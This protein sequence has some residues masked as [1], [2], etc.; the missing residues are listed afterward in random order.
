MKKRFFLIS[1]LLLATERV[2]LAQFPSRDSLFTDRVVLMDEVIVSA[3]K[4]A[5]EKIVVAQQIESISA[6]QV[7]R[8]NPATTAEMLSNTGQVSVQ[9]SQQGGGSPVL[10]G[11]E[12]SRVLLM[13]DGVRLNNIIYRAGHLQNIITMDPSFLDRTEMLFGPSSTIY[14]SDALGGV[15]HLHTKKPQLS[16]VPGSMN[17]HGN[18]FLRYAS[19]SNEKTGHLDFNIGGSKFASFTSFSYSDFDDLRQGKNLNSTADSLWLRP[20]YAERIN[21]E[22]SLLKN[23]NIYKQVFSGYSQYD[24]LEKILFRQNDHVKHQ[25]NLQWSNSSDIPR[26]D[27]LTDPDG[28][29]LRY[30]EWYYGPQLRSL[31]AYDLNINSTNGFFNDYHAG[32]SYQHIE[33]SRHQ[34]RFGRSGLQS[35]TEKVDVIGFSADARKQT[36]RNDLRIGIDGQFNKLK[37]T[38]EERDIETNEISALDTRYPDGDNTINHF[39]LYASDTWRIDD[40]WILNAGMR[41]EYITLHSTFVSTEFFDFPFDAVDQNHF[42]LSGSLGIIWNGADQ[43]RISLLGSTGFRAPDVDDLAKVFESGPGMVIVPNPDLQPEKTY[44]ADLNVTK[45]FSDK[46]KVEAVGFYTLFRDAIVTDAF[47]FNGV[48]SIEYNGEKSAVFASQNKGKAFLYGANANVFIDFNDFLSLTS[49]IT[50]TYG[51]IVNDTGNAP[52]DHIPPVLGKTSFIYHQKGF[53]GEL[54]AAYNGWKHIDDYYLNGEDNEQYATPE[55]MPSWWTLNLRAQYQLNEHLLIQAA[56]E[57]IFDANYRVFASGI[58]APG[59][60]FIVTLR[61]SF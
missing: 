46:V 43:W 24:I 5:E 26:Y 4:V 23:E 13:I 16:N 47:T 52:L 60:N 32:I 41:L 33:E 12:A 19:A 53:R 17:V 29:G 9:K 30:A 54:F 31:A 51:R 39:G 48:D 20:L 44:N 6:K 25:L 59:R 42:P 1:F 2:L 21:G 61:G 28:E 10:R 18:A 14:G 56:C 49:T 15:I 34:R 22:D 37:S 7:E 8:S 38:A 36:E 3:N 45:T 27:R 57:N 58:S 11:F 35:R 55:G 40:A 50:Y